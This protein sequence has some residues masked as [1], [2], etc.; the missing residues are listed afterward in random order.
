MFPS[1][2]IRETDEETRAG[3]NVITESMMISLALGDDITLE[4]EW[5]EFDD[6]NFPH[7]VA[8]LRSKRF[9]HGAATTYIFDGLLFEQV[10]EET[11]CKS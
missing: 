2:V 8:D 9:F 5:F 7:F 3:Y 10:K 11:T 1:F 4:K 6:E